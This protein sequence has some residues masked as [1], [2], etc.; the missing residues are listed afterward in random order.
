MNNVSC[1][2][3]EPPSH[4]TE[5]TEYGNEENSYL[6][7]ISSSGS[8]EDDLSLY[9]DIDEHNGVDTMHLQ[10]E[11]YIAYMLV[12]SFIVALWSWM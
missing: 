7:G 6:N 10:M 9:N 11:Y 5:S 1:I 3:V 12:G 2:L 4:S 8:Y